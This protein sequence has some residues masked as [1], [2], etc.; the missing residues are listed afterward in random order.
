METTDTSFEGFDTECLIPD[1]DA[2]GPA[3]GTSV[4][5]G[6]EIKGR[7]LLAFTWSDDI[8]QPPVDLASNSL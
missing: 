4:V 2:G 1:R 3:I 8:K 7:L 6:P 5:G